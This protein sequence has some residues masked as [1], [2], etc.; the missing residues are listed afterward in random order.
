MGWESRNYSRGND[1][2]RFSGMFRRIFGEGDNIFSWAVPLYRAWGILVRIHIF[3]IVIVAARL[4][5][6]LRTDQHGFLFEA[7]WM[8]TLFALVLLHEYGHCIAC[9]R[10]GGEADDILM[11]P[12][13]GLAACRPPHDWRSHLV[14]VAGG[15]LVNVLLFPVLG[16]AVLAMTREW[17]AVIF[18]PF[19]PGMGALA[20]PSGAQPWWL[21]A[22]W[23]AHYMNLV[24]LL[25]NVLLPMY[26][27]D[28][29][30]ILQCLLWP[31][32]GHR[33]SL[34][35]STRIGFVAAIILG[36]VALVSEANTLFMVSLFAAL[37]CWSERQRLRF[38]ADPEGP[39]AD[40]AA[41]S[42]G[43][44]QAAARLDK[45]QAKRRE[46][47]AKE[48]AEVDRILTKIAQQGMG[49]LTRAERSRLKSATEN[50][51]KG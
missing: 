30:R 2:G 18:N 6:S 5:S 20:L 17:G 37:T 35:L 3:Y 42:R 19:N 22:V 40:L 12:L 9:R 36:V 48:E 16:A 34:D 41:A 1:G 47:Q 29:G 39:Y 13:G 7:L 51:R 10:V 44:R 45:A 24:L 38:A 15:P 43:D 28:G 25:F 50:R 11:W 14:T 8:G 27:L 46:R 21:F 31:R 49:A 32:L 26:P 4:I 33:A 23:S